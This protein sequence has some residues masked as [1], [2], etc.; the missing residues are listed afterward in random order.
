M[1]SHIGQV[2]SIAS[3][4]QKLE[5]RFVWWPKQRH[6]AKAYGGRVVTREAVAKA[7]SLLPEDLAAYEQAHEED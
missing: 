7:A 6:W 3:V 2:A 1:T 5:G 4:R